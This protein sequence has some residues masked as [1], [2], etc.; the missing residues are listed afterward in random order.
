MSGE[1]P[2][3]LAIPVHDLAE[4]RAFYGTLL[5]CEEGRS[6][7]RWVDFDLF[8]H[9]LS[10]HLVEGA[11]PTHHNPVDGDAVPV[12]HFGAI[13]PWDVWMELGERLSAAGQ[14]FV[15]APR[16]RFEGEVGEQGTMFFQDPSGNHLEFKSFR[17]PDRIFARGHADSYLDR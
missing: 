1:V 10:V 15:I 14:S 17:N 13:L 2:F 6:A 3:H 4:A 5:G 7:E 16:V 8:G 12:P 11:G 9:Q